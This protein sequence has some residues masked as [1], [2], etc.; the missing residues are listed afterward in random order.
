MYTPNQRDQN[1]FGHSFIYNFKRIQFGTNERTS[2]PGKT[3][4]EPDQ[5]RSLAGSCLGLSKT[6]VNFWLSTTEGIL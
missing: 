4:G 6:H 5:R 2:S 1:I 3:R